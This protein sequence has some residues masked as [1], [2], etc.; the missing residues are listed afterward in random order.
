MQLLDRVI[1]RRSAGGLTML[2]GYI[3]LSPSAYAYAISAGGVN[4]VQIVADPEPEDTSFEVVETKR[5]DFVSGVVS[6]G[7][8]ET[9]DGEQYLRAF[10]PTADCARLFK[11][12]ASVQ[13]MRKLAVRPW[14]EFQEYQGPESGNFRWTQYSRL[15]ASLFSGSM[16]KLVQILLGFGRQAK[17]S[18]Y[19]NAVEFF[20]DEED[21]DSLDETI[22]LYE[23]T[24]LV[25]GRQL[26]YDFRFYRTHGLTKD[27]DGGWWL[28]EIS[29]T[30]GIIAMP[31][32]LFP[33]TTTEDFAT[34]VEKMGDTAGEEALSL[35]GGYPTGETFPALETIFDAW[36]RA[37]KIVQLVP[38]EPV[39]AFYNDFEAYG[40]TMG[41]AFNERG[42]EAHNTAWTYDPTDRYQRG[43]HYRAKIQL[44][45]VAVDPPKGATTLKQRMVELR[46]DHPDTMDANLWKIDRLGQ[47]QIDALFGILNQDGR[48]A[49][50][51]ALDEIVA[52]PLASPGASGF[53]KAGEGRIFH[54]GTAPYQQIKFPE[55][56]L[57]YLMSHDMRSDGST[58][59]P[60]PKCDTTMMVMFQGNDLHVVKYFFDPRTAPTYV[61]NDSYT[62]N[63]D[64]PI[65]NF[66]RETHTGPFGIPGMF[67]TSVFDDRAELGEAVYIETFKRVDAGYYE[68]LATTMGSGDRTSDY[69]DRGFDPPI[70]WSNMLDQP[71]SVWRMKKF[72][73]D[74]WRDSYSQLGLHS[75]IA[76]PF[77]DR[78]AYYYA[79]LREK[80]EV[81]HFHLFHYEAVGDPNI[82][83]YNSPTGF[84]DNT[85]QGFSHTFSIGSQLWPNHQTRIDMADSGNWLSIGAPVASIVTKESFSLGWYTFST[86]TF[87]DFT[88]VLDVWLASDSA[89]PLVKVWNETRVNAGWRPL[90][91]IKSPDDETQLTQF[92]QINSNC[93]GPTDVLAYDKVLNPFASTDSAVLGAST[94]PELLGGNFC[95][96]GVF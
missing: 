24:V 41:W 76:V 53:G 33:E 83:Y 87:G 49:C 22:S 55:P 57:G 96:V 30:R 65:G 71:R 42:S 74:E 48:E 68:T 2:K 89:F 56:M 34:L 25:D 94:L 26:R 60:P 17:K 19:A 35:F 92:I 37:G 62:G 69:I 18:I 54:G 82:G 14:Q 93:L 95:I 7:T 85:V 47:G 13:R 10:R 27:N 15:R 43:V 39:A 79:L 38:K 70:P 12:K 73:W 58:S 61:T 80:R 32:P 78:C 40:T 4:I 29:A 8:L 20:D 77:N 66:T 21:V 36:V 6:N 51:Q 52:T 1:Q 90:W 63:E 81:S 67:Y 64:I 84:G 59:A 23:R 86:T 11:L 75:A 16:R 5:P 45:P 3:P 31:L 28:V 72:G 9:I 46:N 88:Q 44:I 91:F 50:Y